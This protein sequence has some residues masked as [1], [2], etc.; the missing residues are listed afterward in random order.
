MKS[1]IIPKL[2]QELHGKQASVLSLVLVYSTAFLFGCLVSIQIIPLALPAWKSILLFV[3]VADIAGGAIANFTTSTRQYYREN[4]HLQ[5]PF[6]LMH[7]LHPVLLF[8]V[9]PQFTTVSILMG[10]L[11]FVSV[12]I[13]R[14]LAHN[15]EL[16]VISVFLFVVNCTI[17]LLIPCTFDYLK[18]I[19][20]LFFLKLIMGFAVG[21]FSDKKHI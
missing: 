3:I 13:I 1:V 11:T 20:I 18:I 12:I 9:V 5:L 6:L 16:K 2:L 4:K 19:P 21:V 17:I 8:W 10:A 15:Q 7:L 14:L